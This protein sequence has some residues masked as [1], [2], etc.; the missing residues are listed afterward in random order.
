MNLSNQ[1]RLIDYVKVYPIFLRNLCRLDDWSGEHAAC[2]IQ[3]DQCH[4]V[5]LR[6]AQGPAA[7]FKRVLR[8]GSLYNDARRLRVT[9]RSE[10]NPTF[11]DYSVGF[12]LA[13]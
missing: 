5:L 11:T 4:S 13:L 1:N 12:R 7:G 3:D 6:R 8:G 2:F 10:Y 9:R